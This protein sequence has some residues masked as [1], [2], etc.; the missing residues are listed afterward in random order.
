MA[1]FHFANAFN[2][3]RP[4]ISQHRQRFPCHD[5]LVEHLPNHGKLHERPSPA[6]TGHESMRHSNQFKQAILPSRHPP[7]HSNPPIAPC[8]QNLPRPPP[9]FPPPPLPP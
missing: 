5:R 1:K 7:F 8:A 4:E 2:N 6:F 9:L 3:G